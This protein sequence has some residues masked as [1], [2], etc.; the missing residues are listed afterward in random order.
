M[1]PDISVAYSNDEKVKRSLKASFFDG[2]FASG[3]IGFTQ[4]YFTPFLLLIGGTAR[5]VGILN[6][7][8]NLAASLTQ[9]KSADLTAYLRSRKKMF[10]FFVFLQAFMLLPMALAALFCFASPVIFIGF[11]VFF[12]GFGALALPAWGSLMSDLVPVDKRGVYFGWRNKITGL[13]TVA[14]TLLAGLILNEVG[15]V[16]RFAAFAILFGSAFIFRLASW[17]FL[18]RMHE[19]ALKHNKEDQFT[20]FMFLARLKESNFAKFVLFV[21]LVNFSVNLASPFFPVLML[22]DLHFSYMLYAV[23]TVTATLTV[24]L[25][26]ARWGR[27]ADRIGNLKVINVTAPLIGMIPLLWILNRNPAFLFFAQVFSGFAWAGFNLC[28]SNFIYDAVTP[29]KRTRCIAYFNLFNGL[30][31]CLGSLLGGLLLQHLPP[32]LGFNILTLFLISSLLRIGIGLMGP[33]FLKEVR[34][35]EHISNVDVFRSVVS[36]R[37]RGLR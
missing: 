28:A 16:N 35:V 9:L 25:M 11:V 21:A 22:R 14:V 4:E 17:Y 30:A 3:M 26:I 15:S 31:L 5:Q 37:M 7:L 1:K 18:T 8:Q 20:I 12:A 2:V 34:D 36:V 6:A 32:L 33:L 23:I 10:N 13:I 29:E 19:P 24:C 27:L